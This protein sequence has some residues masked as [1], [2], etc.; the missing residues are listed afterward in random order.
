MLFHSHNKVLIL[1][2]RLRDFTLTYL[3]C[4]MNRIAQTLIL[5]PDNQQSNVGKQIMLSL[6]EEGVLDAFSWCLL[7]QY[8]RLYSED[9]SFQVS[10]EPSNNM[11]TLLL[12]VVTDVS[13]TV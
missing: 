6:R 13:W 10:T 12:D 8:T 4:S 9:G 7:L 2:V 3:R 5:A 11:F 1:N